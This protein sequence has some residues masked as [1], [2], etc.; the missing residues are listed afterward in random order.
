[1]R[2]ASLVLAGSCLA[3][4]ATA[5]GNSADK[6]STTSHTTGSGGAGGGEGTGGDGGGSSTSSS[7]GEGP[8]SSSSSSTTTSSGTGGTG[9][10]AVPFPAPHPSPPKVMSYGGPVLGHPKVVPIFFPS[11]DPAIRAQVVDYLNKVGS[12]QYWAA[13]TAEYGV[14]P[15]TSLS[16]VDLTEAAPTLIDDA[17]IKT[18]LANKL[19]SQDS[20]FP[21]PDANTIYTIHYPI[22]TTITATFSDGQAPEQSCTYFGGYHSEVMANTATGLQ[23]VTYIVMPRCDDIFMLSGIDA[24]TGTES[25][26]LI[27]ASTDPRVISAPA[28]ALPDNEDLA[29]V[30]VYGGGEVGDMCAQV[31]GVFTEFSELPYTVQRSWSNK[32]AAAGQDP[33]QPAI[34]NT[35]YFNSAPVLPDLITTTLLG[36]ELQVKGVRVPVGE[37]RTIDVDLFST[38]EDSWSVG[39]QQSMGSGNFDFQLD[40]DFGGNGDK[41]HLSITAL[42]E[43]EAAFFLLSNDGANNNLWVG[44]VGTN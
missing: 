43:G 38:A 28:Y 19:E 8:V 26:E 6:A 27:E 9:G 2:L 12:T 44:F 32:A 42:S 30:L 22:E 36:P 21:Q 23:S 15:L 34:P 5:C 4:F 16:P 29:W 37:T 7:S 13:T 25:H 17:D 11:D 1:M 31:P 33:C 14:G 3:F 20:A 24:L 18:W 35:I 39:V 40:N 10:S 41:L